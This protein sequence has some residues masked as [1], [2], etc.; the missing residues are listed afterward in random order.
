MVVDTMVPTTA[1]PSTSPTY[2]P[3]TNPTLQPTSQPTSSPT[4]LD[5]IAIN[6][7]DT[8]ITPKVVRIKVKFYLLTFATY[9]LACF[10]ILMFVDFSRVGK[11]ATKRL[12]ASAYASNTYTPKETFMEL[13]EE[14]HSKIDQANSKAKK[15]VFLSL[16]HI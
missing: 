4:P 11:S 14:V 15:N 2:K 1:L 8:E 12:H 7:L 13:H 3:T 9:F 16:I 5:V 6:T 10:I